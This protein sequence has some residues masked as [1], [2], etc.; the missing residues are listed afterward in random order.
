MSH[1]RTVQQ[2]SGRDA[3]NKVATSPSIPVFLDLDTVLL[4]SRWAPRG[5]E[6]HARP[7]VA[8]GLARLRQVTDQ[9]IVLVDPP[10][11]EQARRPDLR[12]EVLEQALGADSVDL[13]YA[14]C[15]HPPTRDGPECE[16]RKPGTALIDAARE[17]HGVDERGGWHIG[18]DQMGVQA[19]RSAGLR[20]IRIGPAGEDHLSAVHRADHD[21]RDLLTAANLVL[22]ETLTAA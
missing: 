1:G 15:P 18:G 3:G 16:C 13:I 12:L 2:E 22:M 19:G 4:E 21:A 14:R 9:V 11:P 8:E 17:D 7:G 5:P 20:T 10:A 6:L